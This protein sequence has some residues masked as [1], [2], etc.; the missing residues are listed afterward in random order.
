VPTRRV[1]PQ[2]TKLVADRRTLDLAHEINGGAR[3]RAVCTACSQPVDA[4]LRDTQRGTTHGPMD[5][6]QT[7]RQR[8]GNGRYNGRWMQWLRRNNRTSAVQRTT[9]TMRQCRCC[10]CV[11]H[12]CSDPH[13]VCDS[14]ACDAVQHPTHLRRVTRRHTHSSFSRRAAWARQYPMRR[15]P[16]CAGTFTPNFG[17]GKRPI[18]ITPQS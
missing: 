14:R 1:P 17:V 12:T 9:H 18:S 13:N 5:A 16:G 2:E 15:G 11:R 8:C 10:R 7:D 6:R 3:D 4:L